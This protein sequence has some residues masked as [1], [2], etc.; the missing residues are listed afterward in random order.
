MFFRRLWSCIGAPRFWRFSFDPQSHILIG[1][2][3]GDKTEEEIDIIT[4]GANYGWPIT[5]GDSLL[6][7]NSGVDTKSFTAPINTY[8]RKDGICVIGGSFYYGDS[9]PFL[10]N[11]YVFADYRET[12]FTL[13]K[14][15]QGTWTRQT[16]KVL[17]MPADPFLIFSCNVDDHNELNLMG[18][19]NTKTGSKGVV[20]KIVKG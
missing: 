11:K 1:G 7:N 13:T 5:E 19:L 3:V 16:L 15:E 10:K 18:V 17:N 6:V 8:T 9:I 12:L 14:N 20:Y 4:K 2:E